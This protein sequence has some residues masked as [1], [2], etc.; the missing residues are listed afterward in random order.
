VRFPTIED[1]VREPRLQNSMCQR[2]VLPG[3]SVAE[4]AGRMEQEFSFVGVLEA[5]SHGL[6]LLNQLTGAGLKP[7]VVVRR[8][9]DR[10][11]EVTLTPELQAEIAELNGRDLELWRHFH[12]RI[13]A[14]RDRQ[15]S[16]LDEAGR[17]A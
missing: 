10:D 5:Y 15:G 8:T 1:F 2:L 14:A 12:D 17:E 13:A 6:D 4:A 7:E 9:E 11:N 3:E 16:E